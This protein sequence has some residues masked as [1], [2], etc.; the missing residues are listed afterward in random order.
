[1]PVHVAP[2]AHIPALQ[3]PLLPQSKLQIERAFSVGVTD[4]PAAVPTAV[5][6]EIAGGVVVALYAA[7]RLGCPAVDVAGGAQLAFGP[8][9][10]LCRAVRAVQA[11]CYAF[12]AAVA[13]RGVV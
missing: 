4:E 1:M 10:S 8:I 2:A 5:A 13:Q 9:A 3:S 11:C 7:A 12:A 6:D